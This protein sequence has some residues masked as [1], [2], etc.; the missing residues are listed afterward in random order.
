MTYGYSPLPPPPPAPTPPRSGADLAVSITLLIL[1]Y[2]G[3]G[4]AAVLAV[5]MLAFTDYC[6]PDTCNIDAGVTAA[7]T[8]FGVAALIAIVGTV[9]SIVAMVRRTRAWPWAL[10][11]LVLC[12]LACALAMAGYISSVSG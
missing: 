7:M 1:T 12:G 4:S 2:L 11:T 6:P 3:G 10:A 9:L 8:G 5:F